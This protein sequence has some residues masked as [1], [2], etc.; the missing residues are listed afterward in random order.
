MAEAQ[1]QP[2]MS[3]RVRTRCAVSVQHNY[4]KASTFQV[5]AYIYMRGDLRAVRAP[6]RAG[7]PG[8][9]RSDT[10]CSHSRTSED[11]RV[12]SLL[13]SACAI[14]VPTP[15]T[16]LSPEKALF[17]QPGVPRLASAGGWRPMSAYVTRPS[18][19]TRAR[20][21][22]RLNM[23]GRLKPQ[24]HSST[25]LLLRTRLQLRTKAAAACMLPGP[26]NAWQAS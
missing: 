21:E 6:S 17:E 20:Q 25:V 26:E 5:R 4:I 8:Y 13:L 16:L 24:Q 2:T 1:P 23:T 12:P 14:C 9:S 3:F 7:Q 11:H 10:T 22:A 18:A 19:A 15:C